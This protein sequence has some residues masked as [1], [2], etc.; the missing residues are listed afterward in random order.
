MN[1][2]NLGTHYIIQLKY[3]DIKANLLTSECLR[4]VQIMS[5]DRK[6]A[7]YCVS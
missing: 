5:Y 1:I 7:N 4:V 3:S 2:I 6:A